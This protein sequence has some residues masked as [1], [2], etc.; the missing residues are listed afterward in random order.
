MRRSKTKPNYQEI[1]SLLVRENLQID[2]AVYVKD[3][4]INFQLL[5][6]IQSMI[7]VENGEIVFNNPVK[8]INKSSQD[9]INAIK[10]V[11]TDTSKSIHN[12]RITLTEKLDELTN[13]THDSLQE[14][15]H[16]T[17]LNNTEFMNKL[18]NTNTRIDKLNQQ[19][20]NIE[21]NTQIV[22][23]LAEQITK[24]R[25]KQ[26]EQDEKIDNMQTSINNTIDERTNQLTIQL[27]SKIISSMN[28]VKQLIPDITPD[29]TNLRQ[30]NIVLVSD[31]KSY[32]DTNISDIKSEL[33]KHS[34]ST[35]E[36]VDS[37]QSTIDKNHSTVLSTLSQRTNSLQDSISVN[38]DNV[39]YLRKQLKQISN[40]S[41][42]TT[43]K[44][45]RELKTIRDRILTLENAPPIVIPKPLP[46][47]IEFPKF[48][49]YTE[50]FKSIIE[51]CKLY[52][53]NSTNNSTSNLMTVINKMQQQISQ[54]TSQIS[55]LLNTSKI[56]KQT[57]GD[58]E[59][60]QNETQHSLESMENRLGKRILSEKNSLTNYINYVKSNIKH[61]T[62]IKKEVTV[63]ES[64]FDENKFLDKL[65]VLFAT[66]KEI[67]LKP[68]N[69]SGFFSQIKQVNT[70]IRNLEKKLDA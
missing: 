64:K 30:E 33:D 60:I 46:P 20:P 36:L 19:I 68:A 10:K 38:S 14:L 45:K 22:T 17:T 54:L 27:T 25:T 67:A 59:K 15:H 63:Q 32:L 48:P 37:L 39:N 44:T 35:K 47:K 40:D 7:N 43:E 34:K 5:S 57:Q 65:N 12:V 31:L 4:P 58:I 28:N 29:I 23:K 50:R 53:D 70:R 42:S 11:Q 13:S 69:M 18:S 21:K 24:Q 2:G 49:D 52:T 61:E 26:N 9:N 55:E 3:D 6:D 16:L 62:I 41:E 56:V 1:L 66:K 51:E 8:Q